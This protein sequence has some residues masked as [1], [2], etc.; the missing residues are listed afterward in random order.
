MPHLRMSMKE[1]VWEVLARI[2]ARQDNTT[3]GTKRCEQE[4]PQLPGRADPACSGPPMQLQ[5][6]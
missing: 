2:P 3:K 5:S 6:V 1:G 4:V